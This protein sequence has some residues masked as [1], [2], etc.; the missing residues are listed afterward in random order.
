MDPCYFSTKLFPK[1]TWWRHQM[2]AFSALLALC[3][4][5]SPVTGEFPAQKPVTRSFDVFFD[6]RLIKRL[7]KH[8]KGW[9]FETLLRPLWRH[10]NECRLLAKW[11]PVNNLLRPTLE[12]IIFMKAHSKGFVLSCDVY[13][14][15]YALT[16]LFPYF[17]LSLGL[18]LWIAINSLTTADKAVLFIPFHV[19]W[20]ILTP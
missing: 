3:A 5:N 2:E 1:I 7:S 8:S 13:T 19:P 15:F 16:L 20:I 14:S 9:W 6:L 18:S 17:I 11:I 12:I 10:C 4:G